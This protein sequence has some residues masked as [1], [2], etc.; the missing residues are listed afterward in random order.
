MYDIVSDPLPI[1]YE[2]NAGMLFPIKHS[3]T[4]NYIEDD[5]F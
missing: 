3:L 2:T 1:H 4:L 5:D